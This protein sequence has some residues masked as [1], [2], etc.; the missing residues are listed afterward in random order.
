MTENIK[1]YDEGYNSKA[2]IKCGR[3]LGVWL[4]Y[5][6]PTDL[7]TVTCKECVYEYNMRPK[8]WKENK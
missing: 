5:D 3:I 6:K 4:V 8:D 1:K 2:C 7:I